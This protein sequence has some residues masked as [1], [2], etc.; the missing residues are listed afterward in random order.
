MSYCFLRPKPRRSSPTL[1]AACCT[2]FA[3]S[4]HLRVQTSAHPQTPSIFARIHT[5]LTYSPWVFEATRLSLFPNT[6]FRN[7][8]HVT[9]NELPVISSLIL[10]L[11][12]GTVW[13]TSPKKQDGYQ[14]NSCA[15]AST[16][17]RPVPTCLLWNKR[18]E[19]HKKKENVF[20]FLWLCLCSFHLGTH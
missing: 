18:K 14:L 13:V 10:V 5:G 4:C 8:Y 16:Y 15:Y 3:W 2:R 11:I 19:K 20:F 12:T 9:V 17:F 1:S 6:R 7:I